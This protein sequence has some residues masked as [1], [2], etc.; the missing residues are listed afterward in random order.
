MYNYYNDGLAESDMV[1]VLVMDSLLKLIFFGLNGLTL[2][3]L[4]S[5]IA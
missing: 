1:V 5:H 4:E 3:F 2:R